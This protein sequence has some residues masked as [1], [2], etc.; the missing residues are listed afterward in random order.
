MHK[1][2]EKVELLLYQN[3]KTRESSPKFRGLQVVSSHTRKLSRPQQPHDPHAATRGAVQNL[4]KKEVTKLAYIISPKRVGLGVRASAA[5]ELAP[6]F[7]LL[8]LRR[9]CRIARELAW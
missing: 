1:T 3:I 2:R 4:A 9:R 6:A 5:K 8:K 7:G